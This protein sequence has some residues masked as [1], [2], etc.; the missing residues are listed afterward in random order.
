MQCAYSTTNIPHAFRRHI[1]C[2]GGVA[3]HN[4]HSQ[5]HNQIV[6]RKLFND[7]KRSVQRRQISGIIDTWPQWDINVESLTFPLTP[8]IFKP[9]IKGIGRLRV[10]VNGYRQYILAAVENILCAVAVMVVNI[11]TDFIYVLV[12]PRVS[13]TDASH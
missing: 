5:R 12:D 9:G 11:I 6:G 2:T 1:K 3:S 8:L 7:S 4:I 13:L 10:P